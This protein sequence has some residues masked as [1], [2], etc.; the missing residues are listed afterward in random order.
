MPAF[1]QRHKTLLVTALALLGALA[2]AFVLPVTVSAWV[3]AA[4]CA[5]FAAASYYLLWRTVRIMVPRMAAFALCGG[6]LMGLFLAAGADVYADMHV[7]LSFGGLFKTGLIALGL[8][9]PLAAALACLFD[10][11]PRWRD[12]LYNGRL[13]QSPLNPASWRGARA[14]FIIWAVLVLCW[15]PAY[16][17]YFPGIWGYDMH[18][19]NHQA[20]TGL[21]NAYQPLLHTL[22]YRLCYR[23]GLVV[24]GT[25]TA[26]VAV[27]TAVQSLILSACLAYVTAYL[28]KRLRVPFLFT[29][30]T[31][32]FYALLP[33]H[34]IMAVSSTKDTVFAGL[35]LAAAAQTYDLCMDTD[36]F[37]RGARRIV[38]YVLTVLLI[39]LLRNNM[40]YA[41]LFGAAFLVLGLKRQRKR[42]LLLV[43]ACAIVSVVGSKSLSAALDAGQGPR[44]ELLNVPIQQVACVYN[45]HEDVLS[46]EDK[47][48]ICEYLPEK[49]LQNYYPLLSDPVK[50]DASI[51]DGLPSILGFLR[52]WARFLPVYFNDYLDSF[53][54]MTLGYWFP[55][56]TFHAHIYDGYDEPDTGETLGYMYTGFIENINPDVHKQSLWPGAERYYQWFAHENRHQRIPAFS[57][58]FAPGTYCWLLFVALF[59]LLYF[60]QYR[61]AIPLALP[62]GVWLTLLLG[63]CVIVRYAYPIMA[64]APLFAGALFNQAGQYRMRAPQPDMRKNGGGRGAEMLRFAIAGGTGFVI[65]YGCTYVFTSLLGLHYLL[66]TALAF[67]LSVVVNYLMCAYWVFKSADTKNAGVKAGFLL[68]SLVGLGLNELFMYLFVDALHMHYMIAKLIAVVLVM[69]WNYISKRRILV[70]QPKKSEGNL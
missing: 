15:L 30:L 53:L 33:F 48:A 44:T 59:A 26:G 39:C 57:L 69:V 29:L 28:A 52:V 12:R 60:K 18:N 62:Y 24:W 58:L 9:S 55:G 45:R 56:E 19:Q 68:T 50:L 54:T 1:F 14:F 66:S 49:L 8:T 51:G 23:M 16:L 7:S 64:G 36:V 27:F 22:L 25:G 42:V 2:F 43:A 10:G 32:A 21:Y 46:A 41:F 37:L 31:V 35:F 4:C 13:E 3:M 20:L 70:K 67:T 40:L 47:A 11:L 38:P 17:G 61:L 34:A 6:L 5:V 65:D 63:P